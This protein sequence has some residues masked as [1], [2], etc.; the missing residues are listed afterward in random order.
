MRNNSTHNKNVLSSNSS[1]SL[2][3]NNQEAFSNV[4]PLVT[5]KIIQVVPITLYSNGTNKPKS[6]KKDNE[7]KNLLMNSKSKSYI[8]TKNSIIPTCQ[9]NK[10]LS[11]QGKM[12]PNLFEKNNIKVNKEDESQ[13]AKESSFMSNSKCSVNSRVSVSNKSDIP[14]SFTKRNFI[15]DMKVST[16]NSEKVHS[17]EGESMNDEEGE[18]LSTNSVSE[19]NEGNII[20]DDFLIL[21]E[22]LSFI[23]TVHFS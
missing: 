16:L 7:I 10:A 3:K 13:E 8:V 14:G 15:E 22:K 20:L 6:V 17:K 18:N 12:T 23:K 11:N 5:E 21:E 1:I 9:L 19:M 4:C 2:I